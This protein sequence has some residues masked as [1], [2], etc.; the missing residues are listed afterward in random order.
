MDRGVCYV[1]DIAACQ[2]AL[3]DTVAP[4]TLPVGDSVVTRD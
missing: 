1:W 4:A 3:E 2:V